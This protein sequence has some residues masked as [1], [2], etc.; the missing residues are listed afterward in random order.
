MKQSE[1]EVLLY[2][3]CL[4]YYKNYPQLIF[5]YCFLEDHRLK[6]VCGSHILRI[7]IFHILFCRPENFII[8]IVSFLLQLCANS[9][10]YKKFA[11]FRFRY[12][13]SLE[14]SNFNLSR[15]SQSFVVFQWAVSKQTR[16]MNSC[17][18]KFKQLNHQFRRQFS[19]LLPNCQGFPSGVNKLGSI[20]P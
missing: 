6:K 16:G 15:F 12:S 10:L 19:S 1:T 8:A 7:H 9:C 11:G 20:Q 3:F 13:S 2:T 14:T 18:I 4:Q 17:I 5:Y